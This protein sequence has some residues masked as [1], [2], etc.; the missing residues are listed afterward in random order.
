MRKVFDA[1]WFRGENFSFF[2]LSNKFSWQDMMSDHS[3][4]RTIWLVITI[5][6]YMS[7][8]LCRSRYFANRMI[9][10]FERANFGWRPQLWFANGSLYQIIHRRQHRF[11]LAGIFAMTSSI[12]FEALPLTLTG[13]SCEACFLGLVSIPDL[14]EH[15]RCLCKGA[16]LSR[17]WQDG[18]RRRRIQKTKSHIP[19]WIR[20]VWQKRELREERFP[21]TTPSS[22]RNALHVTPLF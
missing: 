11:A 13:R 17:D 21:H 20:A 9:L 18:Y 6:K 7:Y 4:S 3:K 8:V 14:S 5:R 1:D 10:F 15:A 2:F 19:V 16:H 22:L 12:F